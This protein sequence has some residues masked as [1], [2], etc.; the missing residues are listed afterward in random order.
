MKKIFFATFAF[1]FICIFS[2]AQKQVQSLQP[3]RIGVF[4]NGTCF[5]KR[6]DKMLVQE[7]QF[8]I[9]APEKVL[10]GTYWLFVGKESGLHSVVVK[11]DTFKVKTAP[12]DIR[13]F[14][15][16][17]V[18]QMVTLSNNAYT[19]VRRLIGKLISF[20]RES[21]T[22]KVETP[23]GKTIIANATYFDWI[24]VSDAK[25][26]LNKD[27]VIAVAKVGLT[28]PVNEIM[29]STISLEK[30]VQWYASYLFTVI[31]D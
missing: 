17:S 24:E 15:E 29:A 9:K 18:G 13:D 28:K 25:T 22:V 26:S 1:I 27:S 8:Y 6:E 21:M 7:K 11:A 4:K 23:G 16:A 2:F 14:M 31:N 10:M 30:G 19:D 3:S 12:K 20:D 5:V